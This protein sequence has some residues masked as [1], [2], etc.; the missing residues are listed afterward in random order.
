MP[1]D[2]LTAA[3]ALLPTE[4]FDAVGVFAVQDQ[5]LAAGLLGAEAVAAATA[6]LIRPTR[7]LALYEPWLPTSVLVALSPASVHILD[8]H[9]QAGASREVARFDRE[10]TSVAV[11]ASGKG[12]RLTLTDM[13]TGY[14]LPLTA[15]VSRLNAYG[16]GAR[17]VLAGIAPAG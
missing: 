11:E 9:P 6:S 3:R 5:T 2:P 16:S 13:R 4:Q 1:P 15:T 7:E 14:R 12:R 8:W 10:H 17:K